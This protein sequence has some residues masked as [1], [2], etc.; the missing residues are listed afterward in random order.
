VAYRIRA[1][2]RKVVALLLTRKDVAT[3]RRRQRR[4]VKT[5]GIVVSVEEGRKGVKTTVRNPRLKLRAG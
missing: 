1:G 2:G 4:K 5:R 3:L